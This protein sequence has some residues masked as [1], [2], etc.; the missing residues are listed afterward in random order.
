M[1]PTRIMLIKTKSKMDAVQALHN[2]LM[3]DK[4]VYCNNC[5]DDF[6]KEMFPCCERPDLGTHLQHCLRVVRHN[7]EIRKSRDNA[8]AQ[9]EN[10]LRWAISLPPRYLS[11]LER[12][13]ENSQQGRKLFETDKD[14]VAFMK[15]F[16]K[17]CTCERV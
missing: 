1:P 8:L 12:M 6:H 17:F 11:D 16:P 4:T 2:T 13:F 15:R 14:L 10:K 3:K 7:A 5:G 9:T